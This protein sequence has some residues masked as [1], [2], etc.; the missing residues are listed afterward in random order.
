MSPNEFQLRDA[1]RTGEGERVNPDIVIARARG[2]AQTRHDRRVR[3]GSVAAVVAV[4]GGIGVTGGIFLNDGGAKHSTSSAGGGAKSAND[5][6]APGAKNNNPA[7]NPVAAP[8]PLRDAQA[9]PCPASAPKP[10]TPGPADPGAAGPLI[11]GP[12]ESV[13]ICAYAQLGGVAIPRADGTPEN[14]VLTGQRATALV[15]SL[16]AA[17]KTRP[18]QIC[19]HYLNANGKILVIIGLSTSGQA[20]PPVNAT[21]SQNPCNLPVTNGAAIR[22]NWS[23]PSSLTPFLAALPN[24]GGSGGP[25]HE[26][27]TG[28]VTGSPIQS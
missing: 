24:T 4:V 2:M 6:A 14:T 22:F 21:V 25:I 10:A 26:T 1:L 17:P 12:V 15:S 8:G 23:P 11:T 19:P 28:K 9:V 27:P 13:K 3:F 20:M 18:S 7:R 5:R 16:N